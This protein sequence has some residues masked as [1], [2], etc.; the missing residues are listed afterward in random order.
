MP[1]LVAQ[2]QERRRSIHGRPVLIGIDGRSGSGKTS[3]AAR[4]AS[5]LGALEHTCETVHL[6]DLYQG[7]S[8]LAEALAPLCQDILEPLSRGQLARFASW[9]WVGD[10]VGETMTVPRAQVV[11]V[12]GVGTLLAP[13]SARLD[14]RVWLEAPAAF[15]RARALRRD[16]VTFAPHWDDWA[17]QEK[18]LLAAH[19]S[20]QADL[21]VD[22]TT[23]LLLAAEVRARS[24]VAGASDAR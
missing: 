5:Q 21:W 18:Q 20:P 2:V 11:I 6:D 23:D 24:P 3:Y 9:D 19:G 12:E 16:G 8:G 4:L 7:W 14:L 10:R 17:D 22:T 13:C 1:L 15:R